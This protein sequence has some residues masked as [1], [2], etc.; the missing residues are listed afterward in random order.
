MSSLQKHPGLTQ[1]TVPKWSDCNSTTGPN[2]KVNSESLEKVKV[3]NHLKS[4]NSNTLTLWVMER[5]TVDPDKRQGFLV[6][7][8]T[9]CTE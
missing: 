3:K 4:S 5:P 8:K 2:V 7:G 1:K 9:S 6:S